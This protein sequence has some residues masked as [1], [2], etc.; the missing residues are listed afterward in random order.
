ML[1]RRLTVPGASPERVV[2]GGDSSLLPSFIAAARA[3]EAGGACAITTSCG[4]L[5]QFQAELQAA[6]KVPVWTSSLLALPGLRRPGVL[7]V[8]AE[9][10]KG[11]AGL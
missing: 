11:R 5:V 1:V 4:F 9:A 3:L 2:R 10:L 6:V 8:D 7:T